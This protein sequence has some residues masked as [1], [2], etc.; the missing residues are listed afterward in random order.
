MQL[1]SNAPAWSFN[2]DFFMPIQDTFPIA[3]DPNRFPLA[4][5]D[6]NVSGVTNHLE[7]NIDYSRE[8]G[9][10]HHLAGSFSQATSLNHCKCRR[11][12]PHHGRPSYSGLIYSHEDMSIFP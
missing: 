6:P 4:H 10:D 3:R 12:K 2:F 7:K 9:H 1:N 11:A 5:C 8:L